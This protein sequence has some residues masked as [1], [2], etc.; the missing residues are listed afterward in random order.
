MTGKPGERPP[1]TTLIHADRAACAVIAGLLALVVAGGIFLSLQ[2]PRTMASLLAT[3]TPRPTPTLASAAPGANLVR[4]AP[5]TAS[6]FLKEFP[7]SFAVDGNPRSWWSAGA[8]AP[9]W[10]EVDLG[11]NYSIAEIRLLPSQ[12]PS[13][14]TTHTIS[15]RGTATD[16]QYSLLHTFEGV[17]ADSQWLRLVPPRAV[18]GVQRVRIETIS[19]PSWIGWRE[20]LVLAGD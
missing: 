3:R 13:G 15:I 6:L 9:Q 11:A 16:D 2:L 19:S 5:T 14:R 4:G 17:T 10:I 12:S 20:I 1:P 8:F 18:V 7:P